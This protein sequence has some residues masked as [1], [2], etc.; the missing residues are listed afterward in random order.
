MKL[1]LGPN[2][3]SLCLC[4]ESTD[5]PRAEIGDMDDIVRALFG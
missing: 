2:K 4:M 5:Y 1:D 3:S